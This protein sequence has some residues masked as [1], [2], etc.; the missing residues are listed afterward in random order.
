MPLPAIGRDIPNGPWARTWVIA[1]LVLGGVL[2]G[3]E[4]LLGW[5]GVLPSISDDDTA[6]VMERA[7]ASKL[8]PDD[9][10]LVG[11]SRCQADVSPAVLERALD[12]RVVNLCKV[13][14]SPLPVLRDLAEDEAIRARVI[15][16]YVP[17][18]FFTHDSQ[19]VG[20]AQDLV[21]AA[22]AGGL[23][24][25]D[26]RLVRRGVDRLRGVGRVFSPQP[27]GPLVSAALSGQ[28]A[29]EAGRGVTSRRQTQLDFEGRDGAAVRERQRATVV[30]QEALDG[31]FEEADR[32]AREAGLASDVAS[33]E[34]QGGSVVFVYYP[35]SGRTA[36]EEEARFPRATHWDRLLAEHGWTGIHYADVPGMA[37]VRCGDGGHLDYR[38]VDA[39]TAEL[40]T[41]LSVG[42]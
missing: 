41:A 28:V 23:P 2:A 21:D 33:L 24:R 29:S 12:A 40:A 31:P 7:R 14:H 4:V 36:E 6:W 20:W 3:T 42:S 19:S 15:V 39:F 16:E 25:L 35:V 32:R 5:T 22:D 8:G 11:S 1:G 10:I 9:L 37:D 17:R 38:D 34:A 26:Q 18:R 27:Y 13:G 30:E